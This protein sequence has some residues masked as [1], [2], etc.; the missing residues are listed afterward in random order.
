MVDIDHF[1]KINDT[2]GHWSGDLVLREVAR[3]LEAA[4]RCY[5][6]VGRFGGEE[7]LF[8]L[9]GC[10]EAAALGVA[11]RIREAVRC[12]PVTTPNEIIPVTISLG[13]AVETSGR[14][15]VV[16]ALVRRADGALYRAKGEGRDRAVLAH[17]PAEPE[18]RSG[19]LPRRQQP[20]SSSVSSPTR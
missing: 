20:V 8:V 3:R 16:E 1:K 2:F 9:P 5:D 17:P 15:D 4:I 6:G 11:Q 18:L 13:V 12:Q 10:D 19:A 14:R 7:F